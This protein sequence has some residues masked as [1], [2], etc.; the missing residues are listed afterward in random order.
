[1]NTVVVNG[2]V[3]YVNFEKTQELLQW[4]RNNAVR[5]EKSNAS[6]NQNL[7]LEGQPRRY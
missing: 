5:E 3:F 6:N 1:M 4:L 2:Q 7:L